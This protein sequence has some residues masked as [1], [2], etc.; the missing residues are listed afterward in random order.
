M[1][2]R[3]AHAV[4]GFQIAFLAFAIVLLTAPA[5]KYIFSRWQWAVDLALP[6]G[7]VMIFVIAGVIL[8]A[9]GPLRRHC[10]ELLRPPIRPGT[11]H[12]VI[13]GLV[14]AFISGMGAFGA[15]ALWNWA[16]GGEPG[17]ARVMGERATHA[18]EMTNALSAHGLVMFLF[19][20]ATIGPIVEELVFRGMLYPAWRDAWGWVGGAFGS[21]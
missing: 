21:D 18:T 15:F 4:L 5:D 16:I 7:R 19:L 10:V 9:F 8:L 12:E 2:D 1:S 6:L 3:R 17:L 20:A 11:R 13:Q 14:L